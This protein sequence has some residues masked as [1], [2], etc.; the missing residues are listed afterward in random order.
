V[1]ESVVDYAWDKTRERGRRVGRFGLPLCVAVCLSF[2]SHRIIRNKFITMY[3]S[4]KYINFFKKMLGLFD[5]F[6]GLFSQRI[7]VY[8]YS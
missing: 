8:G 7:I 1:S 6:E 5:D 4:I 2:Q 3:F